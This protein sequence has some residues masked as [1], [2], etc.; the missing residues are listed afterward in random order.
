MQFTLF[1]NDLNDIVFGTLGL[2]AMTRRTVTDNQLQQLGKQEIIQLN[3][4]IGIGRIVVEGTLP[5]DPNDLTNPVSWAPA[6]Y[7]GYMQLLLRAQDASSARAILGVSDGSTPATHDT[8]GIVQIGQSL[9]VTTSGLIDVLTS[10]QITTARNFSISGGATA[11]N[12][13]FNGTQDVNLVVS[14]LDATKLTGSVPTNSL[15]TATTTTLGLVRVPASSALTI[16]SGA[17]GLNLGSGLT[18]NGSN[19]LVAP[20][21]IT[22]QGDLI[23]G[24]SLGVPR[25]LALGLNTYI[26]ASN[27]TDVI[28]Q[29]PSAIGVGTVTSVALSAPSTLLS[30]SGSPITTS[31]TLTLALNAQQPNMVFAGPSSGST[32]AAPIFRTLVAADLPATVVLNPMVAQWD[33]IVGGANGTP[34]RLTK[35]TVG[36]ILTV[37]SSNQ[38]A[39]SANTAMVNPMTN[40]WDLIVGGT[41]GTPNRLASGTEGQVLA[42]TSGQVNWSTLPAFMVNPMTTAWDLIV[43]GSVG[44][45][46]RLPVGAVNQI[47]T[48]TSGGVAWQVNAAMLNPMT[49]SNDLI[50]GGSSG[51]PTRLASGTTGQVLTVTAGGVAWAAATGGMTNPMTT[52]GDLITAGVGGIPIRVPIGSNNQILTVVGGAP[53]WSTNN[54][55]INP[56]TTSQDLIVGGTSGAATRLG[57]GTNGQV[58]QVNG[59][60]NVGWATL[61]T[62]TNPMTTSGDLI[63]GGTSGAPGRLAAGSANQI[64]TIVSGVPAW[65]A[66]AAMTNPMTTAGEVI[67]AGAAGLP[68]ATPVG[69]NGQVFTVVG[70]TPT[71]ANNAAMLNPMSAAGDLI[72]GAVSGS[73]SRLAVGSNGQILTVVGGNPSWAANTALVNPMTSSGDLIVGGSSG[74]ATRLAQGST[75]QILTVTVGGVA[76]AANTAMT[77]PM[78]SSQD[79]IVGGSSGAPGRLAIGTTGQILTVNAGGNVTWAANSSMTNPMNTIGDMIVGGSGGTPSR[80]AVGTAGQLLT[81]VSGVPSW[82]S[83]SV[84]PMTAAGDL[85]VGSTG[86]TPT[87]LAAGTNGFVLTLNSG[88]PVW[89]ASQGNVINPMTAAN[90]LIVGGS[91]GAA[92]KLA[93]AN[94]SVLVTNGSGVVGWATTLPSGL[95][96]PNV[97]KNYTAVTAVAGNQGTAAALSTDLNYVTSGAASNGVILPAGVAGQV[98]TVLL[99]NTQSGCLIYPPTGG[100]IDAQATNAAYTITNGTVGAYTIHFTCTAANTWLSSWPSQSTSSASPRVFWNGSTSG[101][102]AWSSI[103]D[104]DLSSTVVKNISG[105]S[106]SLELAPANNG[107]AHTGTNNVAIGGIITV[108]ANNSV[109]IGYNIIETPFSGIGGSN[110]IIGT[111]INSNQFGSQNNIMIGNRPNATQSVQNAVM[112][113]TSASTGNNYNV[114]IGTGAA[115]NL[116]QSAVAIGASSVVDRDYQFSIGSS[117]QTRFLS[118]VTDGTAVDDAATFGQLSTTNTNVALLGPS[119]GPVTAAGTN[120]G[121]ATLLTQGFN[122][123]TVPSAG[124]GVVLPTPV[125]G[126]RM[127]IAVG[128]ATALKVYPSSGTQIEA[129]GTD[130]PYTITPSNLSSGTYQVA[131]TATDATTWQTNQQG[132]PTA[133]LMVFAKPTA[134]GNGSWV[135]LDS[136]YLPN[137]VAY[138]NQSNIWTK[139]QYYQQSTGTFAS[140]FTIDPTVSQYQALVLTNNITFAY[141]ANVANA[142]RIILRLT[143]DGT[144]SRTASW[145]TNFKWPGGTPPTLSTA[146]NATDQIELIYDPV[147]QLI[148]GHSYLNL[149]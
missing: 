10:P 111:F 41:L 50:L 129:Y 145:G 2:P 34:T 79:L 121:T 90:D 40:Q 25:R 146:A 17:L 123:V 51:S 132:V 126:K 94:S 12:V 77:N 20:T 118:R 16:T 103:L 76:W 82:S 106:S 74:A 80:L 37:N 21:P 13:S 42:I 96:I 24:G 97:V 109:A 43:G 89:L 85:I 29:P 125:A 137:T 54:A 119:A 33:L 70:G 108:N 73:P 48:V 19:Q 61:S 128:G 68:T 88:T 115:A 133:N 3:R 144:G 138:L 72:M 135:T 136:T 69:S 46:S 26:L 98:V 117:S 71:W 4:A 63:V 84:N 15:P 39:W 147:T 78:T 148:Y 104:S 87:R 134:T 62:L 110:V 9:S 56:M 139:G 100:T 59:S 31:G 81:I 7:T 1:N 38:V 67:V 49:T 99:N 142:W 47:L 64:L 91:A 92:T 141:T 5:D 127:V 112:I 122:L 27:G 107:G 35:G 105:V 22:T 55:M 52:A 102:P 45:P 36:Q 44:A 101:F 124:M 95:K 75:N 113:G 65:A 8:P 57:V 30:V 58:L 18:I 120:Q 32:S 140:T 86:G 28:W 149:S 66:N 116:G 131:F 130:Q 6:Y 143:Q 60:G 114:A 53:M 11:T 23:V 83:A 14:S 93:T